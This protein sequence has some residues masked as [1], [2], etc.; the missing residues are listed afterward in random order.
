MYVPEGSELI[1]GPENL[2]PG[3]TWFGGYDWQ[4]PTETVA[5]LP[6]YATFAS[7]MLLPQ[8]DEQTSEFVYNLPGFVIQ[9]IDGTSS[10]TL[11]L[12]KQA[13]VEPYIVHVTVTPPA[14]T[15]IV[16]VFPAPLALEGDALNFAIE[17]DKDQIIA[18]T[19]RQSKQ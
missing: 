7:W 14:G 9:T 12:L 16:E 11:E 18:L 2:I 4:P 13:G 6:G 8:G 5:E 19:F 10:Y 17:L 1:S 3:Q 15:E